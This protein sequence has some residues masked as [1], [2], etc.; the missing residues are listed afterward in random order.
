MA[1]KFR[2]FFLLISIFGF[3]FISCD[4]EKHSEIDEKPSS[5]STDESTDSSTNTTAN[6]K[7]LFQNG[8]DSAE[9]F[10]NPHQGFYRPIVFTVN[11]NGITLEGESISTLSTS[12]QIRNWDDYK[13]LESHAWSE[14]ERADYEYTQLYHLRF[15]LSAFSKGINGEEDLELTPAVVSDLNSILQVFLEKGLNV[16]V[17][18]CYCPEFNYDAATYTHPTNFEPS[19]E[20]MESHIASVCGVL[21]NY[22]DTVT[23]IEVGMV[24]P[25][26]EM[27]TTEKAENDVSIIPSLMEKFRAETEGT[28]IPL[29]VRTPDRIYAY[30]YKYIQNKN[31]T[32]GSGKRIKLKDINSAKIPAES[33]AARFGMYNDGYLGSE[34]DEGT[35]SNRPQEVEWLKE[36]TERTPYG[37]EVINYEDNVHYL[38]SNTIDFNTHQEMF[39]LNLSYLDVEW[40]NQIVAWWNATKFNGSVSDP[41]FAQKS[42]Y[43]YLKAHMGYRLYV[44]K[45]AYETDDNF[46]LKISLGNSGFGNFIHKSNVSLLFVKNNKLVKEEKNLCVYT[47][48]VGENAICIETKLPEEKGTYSVYLKLDNGNGK[49]PVRFS[50]AQRWN[51]KLSANLIGEIK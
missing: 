28:N 23:A 30:I 20:I 24:G 47:G 19:L 16:I 45:A 36:I 1:I 37:G 22:E 29:L 7:I 11:T 42:C 18:F 40:D 4:L 27:H 15:D 13:D 34:S 14:A 43:E 6:E 5:F 35:Y 31:F 48:R 38:L 50:N 17:R 2:I 21:K 8:E 46:K 32:K 39:D 49:Y 25:W 10:Y 33:D 3:S 51:E 12:W 41:L 9:I 44:T 26:G